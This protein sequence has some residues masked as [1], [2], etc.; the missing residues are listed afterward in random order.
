MFSWGAFSDILIR[1]YF[2]KVSSKHFFVIRPDIQGHVSRLDRGGDGIFF[3]H[4][5]KEEK[6]NYWLQKK[7]KKEANSRKFYW[8]R[9]YEN[10]SFC[11]SHCLVQKS[12]SQFILVLKRL[13]VLL[14]FYWKHHGNTALVRPHRKN[15][16]RISVQ[17]PFFFFLRR[18][19]LCRS[20]N[21]ISRTL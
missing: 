14:L 1:R 8:T 11:P 16:W 6:N 10:F 13:E 19:S 12:K 18:N 15:S 5:R 21:V 9:L 20:L 2:A 4:I 7:K 3:L 17:P